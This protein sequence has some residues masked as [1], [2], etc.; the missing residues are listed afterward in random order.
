MPRAASRQMATSAAHCGPSVLR[1]FWR[2]ARMRVFVVPSG[3]PSSVAT[4]ADAR[5][6]GILRD[7]VAGP[8]VDGLVQQQSRRRRID[9]EHGELARIGL[10]QGGQARGGCNESLTPTEAVERH[11]H[12]IPN[13]QV[14]DAPANGQHSP[15]PFIS[16]DARQRRPDRIYTLDEIQ[17][18][19]VDRRMLD[20]D[21]H[22]AGGGCWR[23]GKVGKFEHA[24]RRGESSDLQCTHSAPP[25]LVMAEF[26][27]VAT[28][29]RAPGLLQAATRRETSEI[30]RR[31]AETLDQPFDESGPVGM[32]PGDEDHATSSV[33]NRPFIEAGGDDR[34]ERLDDAGT[35][36]QGR[37]DLAR[38]LAAEIGE[39]ELRTRLDEWIRRIDE[40]PAFPGG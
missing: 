22:L 34:I 11:Q 14:V 37:Y 29:E 7:P 6:G 16:D 32:V 31:E 15:H 10:G 39:Y 28:G 1:S 24:S 21:Q 35:W 20:T 36:R 4:C 8:E 30:D 19:H 38:A 33:L 5:V 13:L 9:A 25:V 12:A 23:F 3:R 17:V 18:I 2:P 40:H 27:E 26:D